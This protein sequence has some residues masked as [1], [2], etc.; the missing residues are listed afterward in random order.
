MA[1]QFAGMKIT[2]ISL[3]ILFGKLIG[4]ITRDWWFV[5]MRIQIKIKKISIVLLI[6]AIICIAIGLAYNNVSLTTDAKF[7]KQL[8]LALE[9]SEKWVQEHRVEVLELKNV[10]MMA[11]LRE[12]NDIKANPVFG[13]MVKTFLNEPIKNYTSCWRK[14]VDPNLPV[15]EWN[16][17]HAIEKECID[18]KWTLYALAPDIAKITPEQMRLFEPQCWKKRQLTHQFYA[19]II[20]SK[21]KNNDK[22]LK[23]L[24]GHLCNRIC[25][26]LV[27]DPAV[28][29]IYIQKVLFTLK[30][31]HP[32]KIRRRWIE[33]ILE[34]QNVDGGWGDKWFIVT[35]DTK[36][37]TLDRARAVSNQ[38]AT[39]QAVNML[40]L[41]KYKYPQYF[42]LK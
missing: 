18:N 30:A 6:I 37:P 28:V 21:N 5:A 1:G 34:N 40:Y 13:E 26:C 22:E 11:M 9:S 19:L 15:N 36:R 29:D 17:N 27:F 16:L 24:I 33:R 39:I 23:S 42:G 38:H 31:E 10:A 4:D 8:D 35:S 20:L 41:V 7:A 12:C 32:E 14:E 3:P 25:R 2:R